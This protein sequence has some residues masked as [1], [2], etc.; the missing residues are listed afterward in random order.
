MRVECD[1]RKF[2]RGKS[3]TSRVFTKKP[4]RY[5]IGFRPPKTRDS[6][7]KSFLSF[8]LLLLSRISFFSSLF[9]LLSSLSS[10]PLLFPFSPPVSSHSGELWRT[11]ATH[12]G[13]APGARPRRVTHPGAWPS[14]RRTRRSLAHAAQGRPSPG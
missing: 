10:S 5:I 6:K 2:Y 12:P 13:A 3:A 14:A 11:Q 4:E 8:S 1:N 7:R 9:S